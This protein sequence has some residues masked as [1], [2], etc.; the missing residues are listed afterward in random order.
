[1][2]ATLLL[3]TM[4]EIQ[5][6]ISGQG[7]TSANCRLSKK[8]GMQISFIS[9]IT[10]SWPLSLHQSLVTRL[11]TSGMEVSLCY[12]SLLLLV[13]PG[14]R[15]HLSDV[16]KRFWGWLIGTAQNPR[17]IDSLMASSLNIKRFQPLAPLIWRHLSTRVIL[18]WLLLIQE[19]IK[20]TL[21]AICTGGPKRMLMYAR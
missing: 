8:Q 1:M 18:I 20:R 17:C 11:F 10:R 15:I 12:F 21:T 14:A 4:S 5:L 19:I 7:E 13:E 9:M 3:L 6:F 16:V 2:K